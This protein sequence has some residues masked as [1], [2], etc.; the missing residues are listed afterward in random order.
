MRYVIIL[1]L[2]LCNITFLQAGETVRNA[3]SVTVLD[4]SADGITASYGKRFAT[5]LRENLRSDKNYI[6]KP[7]KR[8]SIAIP[9]ECNDDCLAK[10][11]TAY[12]SEI[13]VAGTVEIFEIKKGTRKVS[14]YL[15]EDIKEER[16]RLQV[17]AISVTR[18]KPDLML[19]R[20][21]IRKDR[22][23]SEMIK[24][25]AEIRRYYSPTIEFEKSSEISSSS[26]VVS[27]N[28]FPIKGFTF[29]PSFLHAQGRYT[30]IAGNGYGLAFYI[31]SHVNRHDGFYVDANMNTFMLGDTY[32]KIESAFL[33]SF[34]LHAG[35]RFRLFGNFILSPVLGPGYNFHIIKGERKAGID[36][37]ESGDSWN[38]YYNPSVNFGIETSAAFIGASELVFRPSR[39]LLFDNSG[40][41]GYYMFNFGIRIL[42]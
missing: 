3:R 20:E 13:I 25:A 16:Y 17:R 40:T 37:T 18:N 38:V 33:S 39:S 23:N 4:F 34:Y 10:M 22:L 11:K 12:D 19:R 24:I 30:G 14:K 36:G 2:V 42:Y 8:Q 32:E 41:A 1:F 29:M 6:V 5:L 27:E 21:S 35:Y 28:L 26:E 15:Y 7:G 31:S 9:S